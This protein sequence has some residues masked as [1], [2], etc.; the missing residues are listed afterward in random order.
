[1]KNL[2]NIVR[3]ILIP[4]GGWLP[5]LVLITH[6]FLSRVLH[7]H[8][9]WPPTDILIHFLGGV[10]IAF[11][12]SRCFQILPRGS[13][14][15]SRVVV[16]ELLLIGSL[17]ATAAVCWEFGEFI[18]DRLFGSYLQTSLED[19]MIDLAMGVFGGV[20]FMLIRSWQLRVGTRELREI[21]LEW[22]RGYVT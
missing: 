14:K 11:F 16:L 5:S 21:T 6:I 4:G 13:I 7:V 18:A 22:V 20:L 12:V 17:T 9:L 2:L 8:A 10:A 3:K 15:R 1:M 19:T